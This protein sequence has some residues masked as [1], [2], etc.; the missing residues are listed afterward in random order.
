MGVDH[1]RGAAEGP[2]QGHATE[3]EGGLGVEGGVQVAGE[4]ADEPHRFM[5]V[6]GQ[7]AG[8]GSTQM[9]RVSMVWPRI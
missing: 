8:W 5:G 4:E 2:G 9:T 7:W 1:E 3:D 6:H